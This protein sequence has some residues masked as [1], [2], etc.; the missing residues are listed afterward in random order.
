[1]RTTRTDGNTT[2]LRLTMRGQLVAIG[3]IVM[4]TGILVATA[5]FRSA[6]PSAAASHDGGSDNYQ[7]VM[8]Q[9]G[10]TLWE[11]S[12]R[13]SQDGD[14]AQILEEIVG[15]NNLDSSQLEVGRLLYVPVQN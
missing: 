9:P 3:L 11:I 5:W 13:I 4:L 6:M 1:M 14:Q 15:Y 8:V 10:E 2:G 12:S 7:Q